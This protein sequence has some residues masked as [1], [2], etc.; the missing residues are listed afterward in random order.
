MSH[1]AHCR[2]NCSTLISTKI[3]FIN[4]LVKAPCSDH[5]LHRVVVLVYRL[6]CN[7]GLVARLLV[8]HHALVLIVGAEGHRV[9]IQMRLSICIELASI[10]VSA[11]AAAGRS[12]NL[13]LGAANLAQE[14]IW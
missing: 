3:L 8:Q 7:L 9:H 5:V 6:V 13:S 10:Q 1:R 14:T 11:H 4:C 2:D 12:A